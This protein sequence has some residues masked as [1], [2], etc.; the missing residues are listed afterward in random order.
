MNKKHIYELFLLCAF[1]VMLSQVRE[2]RRQSV[3]VY[4]LQETIQEANHKN[5]M[6]N[7]SIENNN[8]II[9][10]LS[11]ADNYNEVLDLVNELE[12]VEIIDEIDDTNY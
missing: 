4:Y 12:E 7:D 11:Y 8:E 9:A 6:I 5:A 2:I 1:I 10:Q 3:D